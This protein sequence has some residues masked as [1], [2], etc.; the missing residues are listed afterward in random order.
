MLSFRIK[1]RKSKIKNAILKSI[2]ILLFIIT[3][4]CFCLVDTPNNTPIILTAF[5]SMAILS[6]LLYL[7]REQ[8]N[9][10]MDK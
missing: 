5:F 9:Q 7:N 2:M 8:I 1:N 6:G 3:I 4:V 10:F